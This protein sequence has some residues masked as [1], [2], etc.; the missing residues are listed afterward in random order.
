GAGLGPRIN[1]K[2]S[3]IAALRSLENQATALH[4]SSSSSVKLR[5]LSQIHGGSMRKPDTRTKLRRKHKRFLARRTL[6]QRLS[7]RGSCFGSFRSPR[8][9]ETGFSIH[10][11]AR[12]PLER[13]LTRW[14]G[15]GS[16]SN[17][18]I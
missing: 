16:W 4:P 18:V 9:R 15:D 3:L 10:S 7:P 12:E 17:L 8:I 2:K 6:S 1:G 11:Q 13:L 5:R 14:N